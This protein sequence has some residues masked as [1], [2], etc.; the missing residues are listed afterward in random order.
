MAEAAIQLVRRHSGATAGPVVFECRHVVYGVGAIRIDQV[1]DGAAAVMD[2]GAGG[3]A[4]DLV[5][6]TVSGCHGAL[7]LL[8]LGA[9][10]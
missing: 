7:N 3:G 9:V 6:A 10:S 8:H 2:A 1:L 4:T 5:V